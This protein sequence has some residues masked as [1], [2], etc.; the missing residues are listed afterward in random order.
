MTDD[1]VEQLAA[2]FP[3]D[4]DPKDFGPTIGELWAKLTALFKKCLGIATKGAKFERDRE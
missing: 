4:D 2:L 1:A 3:P